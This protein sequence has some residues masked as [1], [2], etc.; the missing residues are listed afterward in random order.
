MVDDSGKYP[1]ISDDSLLLPPGMTSYISIV[2]TDVTSDDGI[3]SIDPGKRI[4][5]TA[6]MSEYLYM[7]FCVVR[8]PEITNIQCFGFFFF[9]MWTTHRG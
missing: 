6:S 8:K 5:L 2:A 4:N 9:K 7:F 3:R 1:M